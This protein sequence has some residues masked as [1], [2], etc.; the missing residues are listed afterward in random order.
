LAAYVTNLSSYSLTNTQ[1]FTPIWQ[2]TEKIAVRMHLERSTR[3]FRGP[4]VVPAFPLRGDTYYAGLLAVDWSPLRFLT[5]SASAQRTHRSSNVFE[6]EF[7]DT[8][9]GISASVKF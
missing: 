7:N 4:V 2:A 8:I 6:N 3:S 5:L 9:G 1:S